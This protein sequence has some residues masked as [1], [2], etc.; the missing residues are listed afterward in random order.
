MYILAII[1]ARGGSKGIPR[2]NIKPF[3]SKPL[4]YWS[5]DQA[6][7]S[8]YITRIIISTDDDEIKNIGLKYGAEVPF[9]RPTDISDD[10]STDYE[11]MD[12]CINWLK[13]NE[14]K[15]PDLIIQ[16]RPTYP[17]RSV[18]IIDKCIEK[19]INVRNYDSLRTVI[20]FEKSPYKMYRINNNTLNPLFE[21]VNGLK[22]PYNRCRQELPQTY[23]H[24]GYV[25]I[26]WTKTII[27]KRSITGNKIYPYIM[28]GNEYHD[29]DTYDDWI[30]AENIV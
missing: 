30:K 12:H 8:K 11:F 5:I 13:T 10:L 22:E 2:K 4:I 7:R 6:K 23:L 25:D 14:K 26:I 29:I 16:L 9:L 28:S 17:T 27:E 18:K 3:N 15:L 24:N 20:P 1:P 19:L 21:E